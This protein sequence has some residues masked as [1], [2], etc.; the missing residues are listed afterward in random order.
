MG[1]LREPVRI[2]T[3]WGEHELKGELTIEPDGLPGL[4]MDYRARY[5]H[6]RPWTFPVSWSFSSPTR[7]DLYTAWCEIEAIRERLRNAQREAEEEGQREPDCLDLGK[8]DLEA[9]GER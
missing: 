5:P 9:R 7:G 2:K 8:A 4:E 6:I 1:Q 3:A